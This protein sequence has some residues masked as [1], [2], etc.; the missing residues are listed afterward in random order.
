MPNLVNWIS[1]LLNMPAIVILLGLVLCSCYDF[2]LTSADLHKSWTQPV[3]DRLPQAVVFDKFE[4]DIVAVSTWFIKVFTVGGI[5][6]L[7]LGQA[8]SLWLE[9]GSACQWCPETS[10]CTCLV[11]CGVPGPGFP[12]IQLIFSLAAWQLLSVMGTSLWE[13]GNMKL[14]SPREHQEAEETIQ[15]RGRRYCVINL[16]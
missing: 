14:E 15:E 9:T 2:S 11:C 6:R 10:K 16:N 7:P 8:L 1:M 3:K 12:S 5:H 4:V 13:V